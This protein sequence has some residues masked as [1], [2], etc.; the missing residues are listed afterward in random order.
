ML[1]VE[2]IEALAMLISVNPKAVGVGVLML[3]SGYTMSME[4]VPDREGCR[5]TGIIY[6]GV[7]VKV[8][9]NICK[10]LVMI[11]IQVQFPT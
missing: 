6:L 3:I 4:N 11:I 5:K 10:A 9:N 1:R 2:K 8:R 7:V